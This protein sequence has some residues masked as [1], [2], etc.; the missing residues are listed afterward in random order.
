MRFLILLFHG[1]VMVLI[2]QIGNAQNLRLYNTELVD[3]SK[4]VL[5]IGWENICVLDGVDNLDDY[6]L[7]LG[8]VDTIKSFNNKFRVY[9]NRMVKSNIESLLK[10]LK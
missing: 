6:M 1:F 8:K 10:T 4:N 3:S 9:L 5:Y 7:V 2:C